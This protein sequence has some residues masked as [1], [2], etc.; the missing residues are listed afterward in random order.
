MSTAV[1]QPPFMADT[2]ILPAIATAVNSALGMCGTEAECVGVATIPSRDTGSV[3]GV[4]G[5]H[6]NVSGFVTINIAE[7]LAMNLVNYLLQEQ[8]DHLCGQVID[9]VGE[10][11]NMIAG[12]VKK[13]LAGTPW[14]FGNVTVPSVIVGQNY[15]IAYARGL[16]YVCATFEHKCDDFVLLDDRLMRVAVSLLRI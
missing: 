8:F 11:T 5:V 13:G 6:G 9:G 7:R 1:Y 10:L 4:L 14:G 15:Q 3:T 16:N 12:G 2:M